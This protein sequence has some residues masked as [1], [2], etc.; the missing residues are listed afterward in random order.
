MRS[1]AL[2]AA[3]GIEEDNATIRMGLETTS[4]VSETSPQ[5]E[6]EWLPTLLHKRQK[7]ECVGR[8]NINLPE[9]SRIPS[10]VVDSDARGQK[11]KRETGELERR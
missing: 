7:R 6:K 5:T 3:D 4:T 11:G 10:L 2:L 8:I 1:E 9:P